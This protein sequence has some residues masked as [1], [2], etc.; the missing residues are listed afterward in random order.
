[1]IPRMLWTIALGCTLCP[2]APAQTKDQPGPDLTEPGD[3]HKKLETLAGSWDVAVTFV[4][5]PGKE[6]KGTAKCETKWALD[7]RFLH[8]K[9]ESVFMGKPLIVEQYLGF[10][11][12][13]GKVVEFYMN[14]MDTGVMY[15]EG[16]ISRDGKTITCSGTKLDVASGK[17]GKIRTVT[18]IIDKDNYTLEWF[19]TGPDGKEAK[20]VTLTHKRK[21]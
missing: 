13:K 5:A 4:I 12:H 7:G 3:E 1:M 17:E 9:Y 2:V 21:K 19:T 18:T 8:Q 14:S 11:R 10:D 6:G 16:E 20:T 15:N